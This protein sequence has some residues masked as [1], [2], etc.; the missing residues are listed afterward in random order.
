M[1]RSF[2]VQTTINRTAQDVFEAIADPAILT[3]YFVDRATGRLEP[4]AGIV[5]HWNEWGDYPVVVDKVIPGKRITLRLNTMAWGKSKTDSYD[6]RVDF[7]IEELEP[8]KTM[9][10]ISESGW[11]DD[12]DGIKASYENCGGWQHM[13]DCAK[14][15]LEH[16]IDLRAKFSPDEQAV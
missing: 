7:E 6:V 15:W 2:T 9:L 10:R 1:E 16:G 3:R 14:A 4:G 12:A 13:A 11:K 5:W 8:N